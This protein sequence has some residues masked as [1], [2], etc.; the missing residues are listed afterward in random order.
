MF[1]DDRR[2]RDDALFLAVFR[3]QHDAVADR[4][5]GAA[6]LDRLAVERDRAGLLLVRAVDEVHQ[7]AAPRAHQPEEADDLA[8][9]HFEARRLASARGLPRSSTEKRTSPSSR[10]L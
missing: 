3:T 6:H 5:A 8:A 4:F 2:H 7:F 9:P 10:G 1:S